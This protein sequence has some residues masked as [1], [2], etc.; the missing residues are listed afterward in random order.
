MSRKPTPSPEGGYI[1]GAAI[2]ALVLSLPGLLWI[3][4]FRWWPALL[5]AFPLGLYVAY[6]VYG[7]V[8]LLVAWLRWRGSRIRGILVTSNSPNWHDYIEK[9]WLPRLEGRVVVLNWSERSTW[10]NELAVMIWRRFGVCFNES[11]V[12]PLV[13]LFRGLAYPYVY[14]FFYAF[15]D[16]K[17]GNRDA[18]RRLEDHLFAQIDS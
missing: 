9:A 15:R 2:V 6:K 17:H 16:A 12:N 5:L 4:V 13:I 3:L 8:L 7:I 1:D 11:N 10:R 14:R 18:L